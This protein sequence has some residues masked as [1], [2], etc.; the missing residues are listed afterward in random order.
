MTPR[1]RTQSLQANMTVMVQFDQY[2]LLFTTP[3]DDPP[4]ADDSSSVTLDHNSAPSDR[5][6]STVRKEIA[7]DQSAGERTFGQAMVSISKDFNLK[8]LASAIATKL[9][10]Y[11][12]QDNSCP[13]LVDWQ[14]VGTMS[15]HWGALRGPPISGRPGFP[16]S[17]SI[18]EDNCKEV[19]SYLSEHPGYDYI[20]VDLKFGARSDQEESSEGGT[21]AAPKGPGP[22]GHGPSANR[23]GKK[24][25][26]V[27]LTEA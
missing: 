27:M 16:Y 8:D 11:H 22:G 14:G 5:T 21:K 25:S 10:I 3:T 6:E 20:W 1:K 4:T 23:F 9:S 15:V 19:L 12:P 26:G 18:T 17:T 7:P 13:L 2:T 24:K